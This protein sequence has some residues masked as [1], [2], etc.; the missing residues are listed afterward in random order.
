[1]TQKLGA[2][3]KRLEERSTRRATTQA[4]GQ[5]DLLQSLKLIH[6][7]IRPQERDPQW[8]KGQPAIVVFA[9]AIFGSFHLAQ[10]VHDRLQAISTGDDPAGK[11]AKSLIE[12]MQRT[13]K[14]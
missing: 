7:R 2:R 6:E 13:E 14:S 5:T 4:Q 3:L 11:F 9:L 10:E 8:L 12:L 1:M